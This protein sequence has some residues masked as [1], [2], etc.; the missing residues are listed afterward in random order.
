M[1]VQ[2]E[3]V[4]PN[5][6]CQDR[7]LLPPLSCTT[8]LLI[9]TSNTGAK[10]FPSHEKALLFSFRNLPS[11]SC[12]PRPVL[13]LSNNG[14]YTERTRTEMS[15]CTIPSH[16]TLSSA[17][18]TLPPY[19]LLPKQGK[20]LQ[21]TWLCLASSTMPSFP[22]LPYPSFACL[23]MSALPSPSNNFLALLC[24]VYHSLPCLPCR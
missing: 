16:D 2:I 24:L 13:T 9:C 21:V 19:L 15:C 7:K 22:S 11:K 1:I 3:S 17:L 8:Q 5:Q 14:S 10:F 6:I 23:P 18:P 20:A 12:I 4:L